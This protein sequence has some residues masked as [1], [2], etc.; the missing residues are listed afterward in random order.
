[1][2]TKEMLY[3]ADCHCRTTLIARFTMS[4][5]DDALRAPIFD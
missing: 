2:V 1:M 3:T 5:P 4:R